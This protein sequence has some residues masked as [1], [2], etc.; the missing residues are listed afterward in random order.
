MSLVILRPQL[1]VPCANII[2][3]I[4]DSMTR[5]HKLRKYIAISYYGRLVCMFMHLQ[6]GRDR[7]GV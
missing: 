6:I 2:K 7:V 3:N 5:E 1:G 4:E